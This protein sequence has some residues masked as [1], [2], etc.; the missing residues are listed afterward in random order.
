MSNTEYI[1]PQEENED[2]EVFSENERTTSLEALKSCFAA[3]PTLEVIGVT[4]ETGI[5]SVAR[6]TADLSPD[7]VLLG[8]KTVDPS[9][10]EKLKVIRENNPAAGIVL[11]SQHYDA[12]G[13][14]GL[15]EFSLGASAGYAYL[16]V[17]AI[18]MQEQLAKIT[19]L[20]KD[21]RI[22]VDPVVMDGLM[23][24]A[25]SNSNLLSET[26]LLQSQPWEQE[27][28]IWMARN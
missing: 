27:L 8:V 14:G 22:I 5:E 17:N 18:D 12:T 21:G 4:E 9:T 25:E 6:A 11:I 7:I 23:A 20:V 1:N 15:R 10:V 16:L 19:S 24:P 2:K 3:D 28:L 13:F 26:V